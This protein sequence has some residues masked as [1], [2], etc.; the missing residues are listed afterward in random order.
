MAEV[1]RVEGIEGLAEMLGR[2]RIA[3]RNTEKP[4]KNIGQAWLVSTGDRF[5]AGVA[6]DGTPWP[7]SARAAGFGGQTMAKSGK[8]LASI[9]Y[10]LSGEDLV[11]FSDD[12]RAAVH[13]EG[14]RIDPKPGK[15]ALAIP[16]SD[17]VADAYRAGV[18]IR[19]Q[20]PDAFLLKTE[21]GSAFIV[22]RTGEGGGSM[23][24]QLEFLF[25]LVP[26]VQMPKR[27]IVGFSD[28]DHAEANRIFIRHFA[29]AEGGRT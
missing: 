1:L 3:A 5:R 29:A 8:L 4:R 11:F 17:A 28:E 2:V 14:K 27:V 20:Y 25:S 24:S 7:A 22:R 9:Q 23:L 26:F 16:M 12:K 19:D 15:R 18:S 6:P 13:Q 21:G 10:E